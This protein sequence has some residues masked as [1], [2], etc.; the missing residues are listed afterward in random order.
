M[1]LTSSGLA[2]RVKREFD[3]DKIR[4]HHGRVTDPDPPPTP[5]SYHHGNLRAALLAA[6]EMELAERGI[7]AF[8]LRAVAKRAH[9]SHAAPAH[10]FGNARGL[11]TALAAEGF[12]RFLATKRAHQAAVPDDPASRLVAAGTGYIAFASRNPALFKLMFASDQPD[13][14]DPALHEAAEAAIEHLRQG[15]V[16]W[17]G[18]G[19]ERATALDMMAVWSLAHGLADLMSS[20]RAKPFEALPEAEKPGAPAAILRRVVGPP[21]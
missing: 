15:V 9:V 2:T 18:G 1:T 13:F 19:D 7:E 12:R 6:A 17:R 20:G 4:A 5:A 14:A 16:A 21:D 11:L 8:S 10:H 3:S